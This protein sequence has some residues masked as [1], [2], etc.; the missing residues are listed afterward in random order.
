ML[1]ARYDTAT[2][3]ILEDPRIASDVSD[4]RVAAYESVFVADS[5][6]SKG[7]LASWAQEGAQG[8]AYR[9]GADGQL[10]KSRVVSVST[11][12][13]SAAFDVC[14]AKSFVIVDSSGQTI[15]SEGGVAAAHGVAV[16]DDGEWKLRDLTEIASSVCRSETGG[17]S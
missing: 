9:P 14:T 13:D 10:L 15:G 12:T 8:R 1:M 3:A 5:S 2:T 17:A 7:A 11:G 16:R 6:F 4:P